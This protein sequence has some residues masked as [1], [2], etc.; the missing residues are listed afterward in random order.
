MA[1]KNL[2]KGETMEQYLNETQMLDFS[3]ADIAKLIEARGWQ[4]LAEFER[5]RAI[6]N[7]VRDEILFVYNT[8]DSIPA[9]K[10]LA[11]GF[12][13]CNTKGTLFMALL[14]ACGIPCRVHGFTIDKKLQKGAMTG[15]VYRNAPE[16]IFHSWVEVF[17]EGRWYELE[18]FILDKRYLEK[19]QEK[20]ADCR[21]AFCGYGVAVKDF[22]H[23]VI[24]FD[25]N[26]TYIQSEGI[27][28][29]FGIYDCPDNLLLEH[30]QNMT[31]LK[32]FAYRHLGRHLMNYNVRKMRGSIV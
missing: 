19:L 31:P 24:D 10:V 1:E 26:N 28:Q 14:R 13:Q 30:G 2:L 8:D 4:K 16:N 32:A 20:N 15:F 22:R 23:P 18:G 11:D 6:Y 12:G 7:Y 3:H 25:R 29:D 21:G 27:T 17:L 9:S 5:I